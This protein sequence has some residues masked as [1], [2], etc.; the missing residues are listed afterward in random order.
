MDHIDLPLKMTSGDIL[1][2]D[3]KIV[4]RAVFY[5]VLAG[6]PLFLVFPGLFKDL[7]TFSLR[8]FSSL[9]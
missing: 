4:S 7:T 5:A 1:L 2:L 6:V 3:A 9:S 8:S